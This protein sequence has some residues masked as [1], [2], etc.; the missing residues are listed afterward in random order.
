MS[1]RFPL[2]NLFFLALVVFVCLP[3]AHGQLFFA[4]QTV[5]GGPGV[6]NSNL[7]ENQMYVH[8]NVVYVVWRVDRPVQS[9]GL[10]S[11]MRRSFDGG[12]TWQ[13]VQ[14]LGPGTATLHFGGNIIYAVLQGQ[15]TTGS[16]RIAELRR[17][18][19][20]G[21]TFDSIREVARHQQD[22]TT[23]FNAFVNG[24]AVFL[25]WPGST[26]HVYRR[27]GDAGETFSDPQTFA[28]GGFNLRLAAEGN[29]VYAA[30]VFSDNRIFVRRSPDNGA[31][32]GPATILNPN[33]LMGNLSVTATSNQL[34]L[35]WTGSPSPTSSDVFFV[36]SGDQGNTF[37]SPVN[38]SN[39]PSFYQNPQIAVSGPNIMVVFNNLAEVF[40][41][42]ST[43]GGE[44]FHQMSP[45]SGQISAK[46]A[47]VR[48]YDSYVYV[49]YDAPN[50]NGMNRTHYHLLPDLG[51]T[52]RSPQVLFPQGGIN[53]Q[54]ELINNVPM[55]S[56]NN[57]QT[58]LP[59]LLFRRS[60]PLPLRGPLLRRLL[61]QQ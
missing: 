35:L 33:L 38:L 60:R 45:L 12:H 34:F 42:R 31:T 28:E 16:G 4:E 18:S 41:S 29:N 50:G 39:A 44:S 20:G 14:D 56:V 27:S 21:A 37:D 30:A 49:V 61:L 22:S 23:P 57:S 54:L 52:Y 48:I 17:S 43:N 1:R 46:R 58:N 47:Q 15:P 10:I 7:N 19:D 53:P 6:E 51:A 59:R 36:R 25:Y 24:N 3:T 11:R 40:L 9:G 13:P 2:A 55:V 5:G 26:A 8:Q 32:F